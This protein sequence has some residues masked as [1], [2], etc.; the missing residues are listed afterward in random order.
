MGTRVRVIWHSS[1]IVND[2]HI[3]RAPQIQSHSGWIRRVPQTLR[4]SSSYV[5][6]WRRYLPTAILF[7]NQWSPQYA[8]IISF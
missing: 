6:I 4:S 2:S 1:Y 3:W 5:N 8:G 7:Q